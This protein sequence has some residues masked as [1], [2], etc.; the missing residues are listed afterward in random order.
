MCMCKVTRNIVGSTITKQRT[1]DIRGAGHELRCLRL[2]SKV[3]LYTMAER[4]KISKATISEIEQR[5]KV[6]ELTAQKY[7]DALG[8]KSSCALQQFVLSVRPQYSDK[9]LKGQKTVELRR[10]FPVVAPRS[11]I[12][13]IYST[14]PE[15]AMVGFVEIKDVKE[16]SV[17]KIW[18]EYKDTA[19]IEEKDFYNYFQGLTSGFAL[20]FEEVQR[21]SRKI[22]LHELRDRFGFEPPQSFLYANYNLRKALKNA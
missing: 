13:Y 7:L 6:P 10:R 15:R 4:L 19:F 14:S 20:I 18:D 3:T 16:L 5:I 8:I 9:I 12:A 21:F 22:P 1:R 17:E 2:L 11:T